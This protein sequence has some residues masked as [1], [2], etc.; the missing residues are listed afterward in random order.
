LAAAEDFNGKLSDQLDTCARR[1]AEKDEVV[2]ALQGHTAEL[3]ASVE[4]IKA[5]AA[6]AAA[7]STATIEELQAQ[8]DAATATNHRKRGLEAFDAAAQAVVAAR[9]QFLS[10]STLDQAG[11]S[12]SKRQRLN[13][14][15]GT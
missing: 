2:A 15:D 14:T 5:N 3:Q 1:S 7:A 8:V 6:T 4:E 9:T 12:S 10:A 13:V 11:G